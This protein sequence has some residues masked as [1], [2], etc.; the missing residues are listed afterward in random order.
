[1]ATSFTQLDS[2][3]LFLP[4]GI[5]PGLNNSCVFVAIGTPP[6]SPMSLAD[7]FTVDGA[8]VF[9]PNLPTNTT[10]LSWL[11]S[12]LVAAITQLAPNGAKILWYPSTDLET[13]TPSGA[14]VIN[15]TTS[16]SIISVK[17]SSILKLANIKFTVADKSTIS[18]TNND[19]TFTPTGSKHAFLVQP[20][21]A[22]QT[23]T[24]FTDSIRLTVLSNNNMVGTFSGNHAFEKRLANALVS[25]PM[26]TYADADQAPAANYLAYQLVDFRANQAPANLSM[27]MT[28]DA[29]QT[30][31]GGR[32]G[33]WFATSTKFASHY[34]NALGMQLGL[35]PSCGAGFTLAN[36]QEYSQQQG[37]GQ[38][39]YIGTPVGDF[40]ISVWG[41]S[42]ENSPITEYQNTLLPGLSG[43]EYYQVRS[44]AVKLSF[45]A[46]YDA[47]IPSLTEPQHPQFTSAA[48]DNAIV[49]ATP[50]NYATTSRATLKGAS[51]VPYYSQPLKAMQH[52]APSS[53]IP[54]GEAA[55]MNYMA[56]SYSAFPAPPKTTDQAEVYCPMTPY[57][58]LNIDLSGSNDA[59]K[60]A[61]ISQALENQLLAPM[62]KNVMD[63]FPTSAAKTASGNGQKTGVTPQGFELMIDGDNWTSMTMALPNDPSSPA[64]K[65]NNV[66]NQLKSAMLSNALFLPISSAESFQKCADSDY[67]LT[68]SGINA[69]VAEKKISA[70]D[71]KA[72][73]PLLGT[74]YTVKSD[75]EAAVKTKITDSKEYNKIQSALTES[76]AGLS[77]TISDWEFDIASETWSEHGTILIFKFTDQP[78][79]N[80]VGSTNS[81]YQRGDF[82]NE[83]PT[84]IQQ[85]LQTYI[86]SAREQAKNDADMASFV[87]DV[88]DNPFWQGVLAINAY[89]PLTKLPQ[90]L[91]GL[92][93]GIDASQ[94]YAHHVGVRMTPIVPAAQVGVEQ[95]RS[96]TFGLINYQSPKLLASNS[97]YDFKVLILKVVFKNAAIT[98]FSNQVSLL[99]NTLFGDGMTG[100]K[101]TRANNLILNGS[102][103]NSNGVGNYVF[104]T[105]ET[106]IFQSQGVVLGSVVIA[107]AKFSTLTPSAEKAKENQV[108]TRF[109]IKGSLQF[110]KLP[111]DVLGYGSDSGSSEGL[112]FEGLAI[113]MDFNSAT[114]AYKQFHF[115]SN[116]VALSTAETMQRQHSLTAHFPIQLKGLQGGPGAIKP[117]EFMPV[118][119]A[120]S[121][122]GIGNDWYGLE[123]ELNLGGLGALANT[124]GFIA[125]LMIAWSPGQASSGNYPV[126]V[127]LG[128]PG[129]KGGNRAIS[130]ESIIK[131]TFG[132]I[133]LISSGD[134][135]VLKIANIALKLLSFTFPQVGQT[136]LYI[137]GDP[138]D[139]SGTNAGWYGGYAKQGSVINGS[140]KQ[141]PIGK[142]KLQ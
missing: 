9:L 135:Y 32:T 118:D 4:T 41:G 107:Q 136:G 99:I 45:K 132:D 87:R 123:Y 131:L 81:W 62:R 12:A 75:F 52:E 114:P 116:Q 34:T 61:N 25:G 31:L 117:S 74:R 133:A 21:I 57:R 76:A 96:N 11:S 139:S 8:L 141:Q 53:A 79:S 70:G 6:S 64:L 66:R 13:I 90:E 121:S 137:F 59:A 10:Q 20:L 15:V 104:S 110:Q 65:L 43:S 23:S 54:S 18:V 100:Q 42:D 16:G 125:R 93:A 28:F 2:T 108:N 112:A 106:A 68:T 5:S 51:A 109:L 40:E 91:E 140:G 29:N 129:V 14:Q 55:F 60:L 71:A 47:Y 49:C 126:Y 102:Y 101:G 130:L 44:N 111:V 73:Q 103:Q 30:R 134:S 128:L 127:G 27:T 26:Y 17:D 83:N 82:F 97:D 122:S 86:S 56:L 35:T 92:A 1:M 22:P 3:A 142:E 38:T 33:W 105:T 95:K 48:T 69:L 39:Y 138:K 7:C 24:E 113:D 72:L 58:G 67:E 50:N 19:L 115:I 78:M 36:M 77:I 124:A 119:V 85:T 89:V 80:L 63:S 94:F 46:G 88:L 98:G 120:F 37:A 84:K